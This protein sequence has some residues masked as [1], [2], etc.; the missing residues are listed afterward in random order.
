MARAELCLGGAALLLFTLVMVQLSSLSL[1]V[2]L[3]KYPHAAPWVQ[4]ACV[5]LAC[6]RLQGSAG[7]G[8]GRR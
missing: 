6:I 7:V 1:L 8:R 2:P 5:G 3:E 4:R